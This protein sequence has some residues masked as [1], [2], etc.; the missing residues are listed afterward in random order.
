[1]LFSGR[2]RRGGSAIASVASRPTAYEGE[3][4]RLKTRDR[5]PRRANRRRYPLPRHQSSPRPL[6][7]PVVRDLADRQPPGRR[8]RLPRGSKTGHGTR[9]SRARVRERAHALRRRERRDRGGHADAAGLRRSQTPGADRARQRRHRREHRRR[10]LQRR[11][12]RERIH[13]PPARTRPDGGA[14]RGQTRAKVRAEPLRRLARH[15]RQGGRIRAGHR[16]ARPRRG[17]L[18]GLLPH[19]SPGAGLH[20]P[21]PLQRRVPRLH[22]T[23][24][25]MAPP[26]VGEGREGKKIRALARHSP[27]LALHVHD[28]ADPVPRGQ[29]HLP[30]HRPRHAGGG[31]DRPG[32]PVRGAR[33]GD[34]AAGRPRGHLDHA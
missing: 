20:R 32:G 19:P 23:S 26:A 16:R 10:F 1:M 27:I 11:V 2:R 22:D 13:P 3:K 21:Q 24:G 9:H 7:V 30:A 17:A 29:L 34:A 5:H 4:T 33:A 14:L 12:V 6:P 15:A 18:P 28:P 25:T 31:G 8:T